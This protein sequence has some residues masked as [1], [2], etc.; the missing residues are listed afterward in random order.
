MFISLN[1]FFFFSPFFL[2]KIF[3][4]ICFLR[5]LTSNL[6]TDGKDYVAYEVRS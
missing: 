5:Y 2:N 1:C 4:L 6:L 3:Y